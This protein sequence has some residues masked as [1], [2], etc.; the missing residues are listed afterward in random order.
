MDSKFFEFNQWQN[1]FKYWH[2][3]QKKFK[4]NLRFVISTNPYTYGYWIEPINNRLSDGDI[5]YHDDQII[6]LFNRINQEINDAI[7]QNRKPNLI[8]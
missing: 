6:D 1:A 4:N 3:N 8:T 5:V 7:S 2:L